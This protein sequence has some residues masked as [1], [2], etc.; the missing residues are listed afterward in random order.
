MLLS[1]LNG[2]G[3]R[4]QNF[5]FEIA[6]TVNLPV[7]IYIINA[8]FPL[9]FFSLLSRFLLCFRRLFS[10]RAGLQRGAR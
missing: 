4:W 10:T 6:S 1:R 8:T 9:L 2:D 7:K 3:T 5:Q